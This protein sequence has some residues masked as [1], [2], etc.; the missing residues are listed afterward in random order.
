MHAC[1]FVHVLV[2]EECCQPGTKPKAE[3][4]CTQI[5]SCT[6]LLCTPAGMHTGMHPSN[7][8]TERS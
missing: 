7:E 5:T 4:S 1:A 6:V 8:S 2:L 3:V